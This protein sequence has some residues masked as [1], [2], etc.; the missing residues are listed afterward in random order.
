MKAVKNFNYLFQR[1]NTYYFR[2]KPAN[3][4]SKSEITISLKTKSIADAVNAWQ[5]LIPYTEKLKQLAYL[6][7]KFNGTQNRLFIEEI[8]SGMLKKL[9]LNQIDE[10]VAESEQHCLT[11]AHMMKASVGNDGISFSDNNRERLLY[12]LGDREEESFNI[13]FG[14]VLNTLQPDERDSF[15]EAMA[16]AGYL[17]HKFG[18]NETDAFD[19]DKDIERAKELLQE[20]GFVVEE[21]SMPF[22]V[23]LSKMQSSQKIQNELI[24]SVLNN[25]AKK[26]RELSKMIAVPVINTPVAS[27]VVESNTPLFSEVYKEFIAHK[28]NKEKLADKILKSYERIYLVWQAISEN[29]PIDTYT[30]KNIGRFIDRCFELPRMNI[31]PYSRMTWEQRLNADVPEE[32]IQAPKSIHQYYKWVMGVFAFAKRDTVA[33]ITSSPCTIKRNFKAN[34]RGVFSEQ[35]LC[36]FLKAANSENQAWKK[37]IIYLGIFTGARRGELIQLRK[38]N[39]KYDHDSKRYYLLITDIHESQ[40]LKTENSKRK[41]PLHNALV[42]AGFIDYLK[43]CKE[44][45]FDKVTNPEVVTAWMPRKM[46]TLGIKSTNELDHIRSFHSF[47]HSFISKLMSQPEINI[48]LLQQVVGH[49]ISTFGTTSVYTHRTNNIKELIAIVDKFN[50][51]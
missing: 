21:N 22:K 7:D 17:I 23:L 6:S 26:E 42:E 38:E 34:V 18:L 30:P 43:T 29:K 39:V 14:K 45:V 28:I 32:H 40:N 35:E 51:D 11:S 50:I 4:L 44:R 8:K 48:N 41:I 19:N 33:Y 20:N 46:N 5:K 25:E 12:L 24:L 10:L 27:K 1:N 2:F 31:L 9:Q 49:E 13:R 37:W 15:I 3:K 36:L 47:R 16:G